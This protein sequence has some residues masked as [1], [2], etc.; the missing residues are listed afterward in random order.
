MSENNFTTI[1][2][3]EPCLD[4][5]LNTEIKY[6]RVFGE[7]RKI[8]KFCPACVD[9]MNQAELKEKQEREARAKQASLEKMFN[10]TE[11][12]KRFHSSTF[13]TYEV[14]ARNQD[15][16]VK[17]REYVANWADNKR[18]GKGIVFA[19]STG[20]GK[21][22]LMAAITHELYGA[23][24]AVI[25]KSTPELLA[26]IKSAFEPNGSA[27]ES[28]VF[29]ALVDADL[30]LIDDVGTEYKTGWTESVLYMLINARYQHMR[31]TIYSTNLAPKDFEKRVG[32]RIMDR[33][34]ET[35]EIVVMSWPSYRK[36]KQLQIG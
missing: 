35:S 32:E 22:H 1:T 27:T 25:Y 15:A 8:S 18:Q 24:V 3:L 9:K 28:R 6:M 30:L 10:Q 19:G 2:K 5:G 29:Q 12:G 20:T 11:L 26:K 7:D 17:A 33:I 13:E 34:T 31:P 14:T 36:G 16:V 21:S 4:C 23:G